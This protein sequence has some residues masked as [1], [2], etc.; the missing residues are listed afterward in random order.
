MKSAVLLAS[1]FSLFFFGLANASDDNVSIGRCANKKYSDT[2]SLSKD[3]EAPANYIFSYWNSNVQC[4]GDFEGIISSKDGFNVTLKIEVNVDSSG[5]TQLYGPERITIVP[6]P[7]WGI[8]PEE[9]TV[10]EDGTETEVLI[11]PL[12]G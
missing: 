10:A 3:P 1:I 9:P 4:S 2:Y 8:W 7:G 5:E 11:Y 12:L 6:P